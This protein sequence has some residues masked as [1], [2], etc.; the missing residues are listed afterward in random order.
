MYLYLR[1]QGTISE[2]THGKFLAIKYY[3]FKS[4]KTAVKHSIQ[5]CFFTVG[6]ITL[7]QDRYSYEN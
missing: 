4:L 7:K 6:N 1:L 3:N 5:D 2:I